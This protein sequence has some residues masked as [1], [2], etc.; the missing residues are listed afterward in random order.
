MRGT[1]VLIF[2]VALGAGMAGAA[3]DSLPELKT[4][5]ES[6]RLEDRPPIYME[7]ARI[8]LRNADKLYNDGNVDPARA[9]V[10]DIVGSSQKASEAAIKT[11]K[12]LKN[13][14]IAVRKMAEKLRDIKRTL[15]VEDQPPVDAAI[16]QLEDM[17]TG[18]LE[19]MFRKEKK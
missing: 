2:A 19:A 1:K 10:E 6:T 7:I 14:E 13:V 15:N 18:L 5:A 16:K 4:R 9:A 17:R 8:Q 11:K 3:T 12:H